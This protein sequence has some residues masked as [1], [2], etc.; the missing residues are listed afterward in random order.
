MH[1]RDTFSV[2]TP[3]VDAV[4]QSQETTAEPTASDRETPPVEANAS[5]WHEQRQEIVG[6]DDD[7]DEFRD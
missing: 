3:I 7:R 5:D 2:E 4:E 6:A 1:D